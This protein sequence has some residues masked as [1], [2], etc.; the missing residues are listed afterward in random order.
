VSVWFVTPAYRRYAL[1]AVCFEQRRQVIDELSSRGIEAKCVVIADDDNVELAK[2][3][4]FDVVRRDNRWL[5]RRFN[6]GIEHALTR[7]AGWI[8]PIGSDDWI[9]PD[10]FFPLPED[11]ARTSHFYAPV[12]ADRLLQVTTQAVEGIG[13]RMFPRSAFTSARPCEEKIRRGVDRSLLRAIGDI[14]WEYRDIHPLQYVGFRGD[15]HITLYA[16]I[17]A[18]QG[19]E[20]SMQPWTL[21]ATQFPADLV[22]QARLAMTDVGRPRSVG[23]IDAWGVRDR[24]FHWW[25]RIWPGSD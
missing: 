14:S 4:G 6:D 10:Y 23:R 12:E 15:R 25:G 24:L 18:A 5:G 21:L 20:E 16:K 2:K 22:E 9:D 19:G 7:G 1:S 3:Q 8:V 11:A 17:R 13:P